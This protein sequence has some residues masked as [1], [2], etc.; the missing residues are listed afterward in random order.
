MSYQSPLEARIAKR[1]TRAIVDFNLIED[2]D[3]V[4]VDLS[5]GKDSWALMQTLDQLRRRAP[6]AFSLIAV[7]VDSG[8]KATSSTTS[9]PVPAANAAGSTASNTRRSAKSWTTCSRPAPRPVRCA[10][11]C[12]AGSCTESRA[13]W[14]RPRSRSATTWTTS[15][16]R[17]LLSLFFGGALRAMPARLVSDNGRARR[18]P[19]A[20]LCDGGGGEA[21]RQAV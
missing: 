18:D 3:R 16:R 7:T 5:G 6:V 20:R 21:L 10:R 12:G 4:M 11:A 15:S 17:C 2:G 8:Y 19:T 13:K 14:A 1:T 9:S